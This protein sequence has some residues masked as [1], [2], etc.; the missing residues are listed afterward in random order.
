M[1]RRG[2]ARPQAGAQL[3]GNVLANRPSGPGKPEGA[4]PP[5]P[6]ALHRPALGIERIGLI[7]LRFP[8]LAAILALVLSVCST[9]GVARITVADSLGPLFRSATPELKPSGEATRRS[10][11]RGATVVP[12]SAAN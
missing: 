4:P 1:K 3:Q 5:G 10:P 11:A 12:V 9:S 2:V 7:P 6:R 8:M